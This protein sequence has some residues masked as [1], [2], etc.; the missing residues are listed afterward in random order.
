MKN[1]FKN[2]MGVAAVILTIHLCV[3][4]VYGPNQVEKHEVNTTSEPIKEFSEYYDGPL[5]YGTG[6]EVTM[7]P[8]STP[9]VVETPVPTPT[10]YIPTEEEIQREAQ[11]QEN[12]Y[13]FAN[14][15]LYHTLVD[16][17]DNFSQFYANGE[18]SSQMRNLGIQMSEYDVQYVDSN[19]HTIYDLLNRYVASYESGN[20]DNCISIGYNLYDMGFN[21]L[22]QNTLYQ[23]LVSNQLPSE[24]QGTVD[25]KNRGNS[26]YDIYGCIVLDNGKQLGLVGRN[27]DLLTPIEMPSD[28]YNRMHTVA[29]WIKKMPKM[30]LNHYTPLY[31]TFADLDQGYFWN[32]TDVEKISRKEWNV[33]KQNGQNMYGFSPDNVIIRYSEENNSY[34]Y[35]NQDGYVYGPV[36]YEDNAKIDYL[37]DLQDAIVSGQGDVYY[38]DNAIHN[39][40][41]D[42][43][44][45]QYSK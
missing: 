45:R 21:Y 27:D 36:N 37:Y 23:I 11:H 43:Q 18:A 12:L 7:E 9:N 20:Y 28:N 2:L 16:A 13:V 44:V 35:E 4:D 41:S 6:V 42:Q 32:Q 3:K 34:V 1:Y 5:F 17:R 26:I 22:D 33:L 31:D 14:E 24:Y 25:F 19:L 8:V 29:N 15:E 10:V 40:I 38:L 30:L 39:M